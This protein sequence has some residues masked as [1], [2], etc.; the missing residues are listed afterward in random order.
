MT[1]ITNKRVREIAA[2]KDAR[3]RHTAKRF[4]IEGSL[5]VEEALKAGFPLEQVFHT[6]KFEES[7]AGQRILNQCNSCQVQ[8]DRMPYKALQRISSQEHSQGILAVGILRQ[9]SF[10]PAGTGSEYLDD[11]DILLVIPYLSDPGN[12]GTIIRTAHTFNVRSIWV[13]EGSVDPWHPKVVRGS[14]GSLFHLRVCRV[15]SLKEQV[16]AL[17]APGGWQ[18]LA[19]DPT[20]Q[21][22]DQRLPELLESGKLVVILGH[23]AEGIP[24]ELLDICDHR[25]ALG[26]P[27]TGVGSLNVG[28]AAGIL[29]YLLR[30][31]GSAAI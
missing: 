6:A 1:G 2:L 9:D 4:L 15:A 7:D 5:C 23:E 30:F 8:V 10:D 3:V 18:I 21:F 31:G 26:R 12:L 13:G 22:V 11:E 28:I 17:A 25:I 14:M 16:S 24:Q 19:L 20:G 29:L 27:E